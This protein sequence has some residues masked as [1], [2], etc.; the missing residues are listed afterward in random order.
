M[1]DIARRGESI[2]SGVEPDAPTLDDKIK[3]AE[4]RVRL[5]HADLDRAR[6][7]YESAGTALACLRDDRL[8]ADARA[9][10]QRRAVPVWASEPPPGEWRVE[11]IWPDLIW[12]TSGPDDFMTYSRRTGHLEHKRSGPRLDVEATVAAWAAWRARG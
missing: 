2:L 8:R 4:E 9:Y 11:Q 1:G 12:L 5:A 3:A 7:E 10:W 6:R